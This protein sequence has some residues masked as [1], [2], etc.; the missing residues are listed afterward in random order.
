M[1]DI[2]LREEIY[3]VGVICCLTQEAIVEKYDEVEIPIYKIPKPERRNEIIITAVFCF[4]S[5]LL[6]SILLL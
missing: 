4:F 6:V 2:S 5:Q 1:N 3:S